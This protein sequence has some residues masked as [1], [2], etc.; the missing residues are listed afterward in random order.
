MLVGILVHYTWISVEVAELRRLRAENLTLRHEDPGL[1]AERRQ[2]A[3]QGPGPPEHGD[4]ARRHGRARAEP[5]GRPGRRR[6][7]A[8]VSLETEPP[9]RRRRPVVPIAWTRRSSDL[10]EKS[11][12]LED[13]LSR[14]RSSCWPRPPRSG[15]SAATCPRRS[16]TAST[17]SPAARTSTPASTSRPRSAPRSRRPADGVV[18]FCGVKGGY[19]NAI[20][21]DHGYGVVTR[22]APPRR[23]QREARPARPPRRRHRLRRAAPAASNGAAPALR[24]VGQ[25]PG[26]EPDPV[27]PRR[28]PNLRL[29]SCG[30]GPAAARLHSDSSG[31]RFA[32]AGTRLLSCRDYEHG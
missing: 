32:K 12:K 11:S 26:P 24:G 29:G 20:V 7:R 14:T 22:Y 25:R 27:H 31:P 13:V 19:G 5:A 21:I 16:A 4:E 3:G 8:D 9:A 15:P 1:R 23:L 18:I 17:P 6:R 2:A 30:P 10:T 28:V